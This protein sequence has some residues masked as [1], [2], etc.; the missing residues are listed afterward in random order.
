MKGSLALFN[1]PVMHFTPDQQKVCA[2][3]FDNIRRRLTLPKYSSTHFLTVKEPLPYSFHSFSPG[4]HTEA[5]APS[6]MVNSQIH[7]SPS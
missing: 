2:L 6:G 4:R 5:V 1:N 7:V 3:D